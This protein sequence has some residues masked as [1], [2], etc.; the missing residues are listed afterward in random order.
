MID[1]EVWRKDTERAPWIQGLE[2]KMEG[3][4][5]S[6]A[7]GMALG[8]ERAELGAIFLIVGLGIDAAFNSHLF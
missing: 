6:K 8:K 3:L 5:L 1:T 4:L 7:Q 2:E